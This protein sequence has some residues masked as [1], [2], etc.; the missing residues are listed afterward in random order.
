M[1]PTGDVQL[2]VLDGGGAV[3]VPLTSV[4]AC[5]GTSSSGTP[6]QVV[7][8]RNPNTVVS[9]FGQGP[10]VEYASMCI[11]AGGTALCMKT[12]TNTPGEVLGADAS[13]LSIVSSTNATPIVVTTAT[14]GMKDGDI[15]TVAGHLV[16]TSADGSWVIDVAS[17]TTFALRGAVGVGIGAGTGT[18]QPTG[19]NMLDGNG[20]LTGLGTA[21]PII[22]GTPYDSYFVKILFTAGGTTGTAGIKFRISLDG[23]RTYGPVISLGTAL[24]YTIP[25]TGIIFT[26]LTAKTVTAN[27]AIRFS[28]V[29]PLWAT[30]GI[31]ACLNALQAS[32]YGTSGWGSMMITGA[33]NGANTNA[34][35]GFLNTLAAGKIHTRAFVGARDALTPLAWGGPGET[36]ATW[37]SS[38]MTDFSATSANRVSVSAGHYNIPSRIPKSVAG[39]PRYRRS[40]AWAL[41]ARQI[42]IPPQRHHGRVK[43]GS[44]IE[45]ATD[46]VNDPTDGFIYHDERLSPGFDEAKFASAWTRVKKRGWWNKNPNLMSD[47]GSVF[48]IMP[49]GTVMD[50]ACGIVNAVGTE[51]INEDVR[52]NKNGTLYDNEAIAIEKRMGQQLEALMLN[53][54]MISDYLVVVDRANNVQATSAVNIAVTIWSRGYILEENITIGFGNSTT[55]S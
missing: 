13:P 25:D 3:S 21:V 45:I 15:V 4:Q 46:P 34:L 49:L 50:I 42:A 10:L 31:Q 17:A 36:E 55:E 19:V 29:E 47:T 35:Q 14:H 20:L 52:L 43:D 5:F 18:V 32:A 27:S 39:L 38:V 6:A 11:A 53:K 40:F 48:T 54:N 7:A 44:L 9:V 16:N 28:T 26:F 2:N 23:G 22:S 12:E 37:M 33:F 41:A 8:T 51:D 1:P 30:A 24:S